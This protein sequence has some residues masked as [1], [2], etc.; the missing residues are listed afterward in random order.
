MRMLLDEAD[1]SGDGYLDFQEFKNATNDPR[2]KAAL[3][4]SPM[5]WDPP[6][7]TPDI[8]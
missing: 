1:D 2:I 7:P 6:T 5:K 4:T 3:R 8:Q